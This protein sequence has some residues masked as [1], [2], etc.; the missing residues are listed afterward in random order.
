MS[1]VTAGRA[2]RAPLTREAVLRR[3]VALA[4]ADGLPAVTMRRLAEELGVEAMSLYHHVPGK[5]ALLDGMAELVFEEM[6]EATAALPGVDAVWAEA[7]RWFAVVR[8]RVLAARSVLL[9]HP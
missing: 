2:R 9:R 5:E 1:D 3:A 6:V 8:E 7:G 4:D